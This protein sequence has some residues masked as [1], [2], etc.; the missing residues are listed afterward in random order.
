MGR[1][2]SIQRIFMA[3]SYGKIREKATA[4][5]PNAIARELKD[6]SKVYELVYDS[7][8]GILEDVVFV[9]DPKYGKQWKLRIKDGSEH[10]QVQVLED[11]RY[12]LDLLKKLPNLRKGG[13]YRFKPYDFTRNNKRK[14]GI[15]ITDQ[16]DQKIESFF[17]KF[18]GS[19][20][21]GW[22]VE[23]LHGFPPFTGNARDKDDLKVYFIQVAKFLRTKA[24]EH[25]NSNFLA[26]APAI[27]ATVLDDT[28]H[29]VPDTNEFPP[30][31]DDDLPF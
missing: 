25:I 9:D 27:P 5:T 1:E 26:G 8:S 11:S 2:Q 20:A 16:T 23:D 10:Y 17:Q 15:A 4:E 7:I 30:P 3:I 12:G 19:D 29:T 31:G 13:I 22:T 6:K 18:T 24:L 21:E 14:A 28:S